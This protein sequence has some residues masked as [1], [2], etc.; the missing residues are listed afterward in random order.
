SFLAVAKVLGVTYED[1]TKEEKNDEPQQFDLK[2]AMKHED[3]IMSWQGIPIP[4]E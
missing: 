4:P 1:L 3:T 2:A